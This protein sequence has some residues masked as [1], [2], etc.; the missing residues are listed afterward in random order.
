LRIEGRHL[1]VN[2]FVQK[3]GGI[4]P[5]PNFFGANPARVTQGS[6]KGLRVLAAEEDKARLL[7]S[8]LDGNQQRRAIKDK[9][10]PGDII[11]GWEPRVKM[12][13]PDGLAVSEMTPNQEQSL[14]DL[15]TTYTPRM[16]EDVA[17]AHMN[18]IEK[19]GKKYI[20]FVWLGSIE[21]GK[22]HYYRLHGPSFLVE[23]D[24]TQ[25]K[26]NHIHSVWRDLRNDWGEDLLKEHYTRSHGASG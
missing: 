3:G 14:M 18:R 22:P 21:K 16:P 13:D 1:S 24:N 4:A 17:N 11:T 25:N 15:V 12:D 20:H 10:P 6:L 7:F 2:F 26:A 23:Y 5:T 9:D 19:E 8:T